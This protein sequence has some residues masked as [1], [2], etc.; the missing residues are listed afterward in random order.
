MPCMFPTPRCLA[1]TGCLLL[2]RPAT[3]VQAQSTLDSLV[4][5]LGAMTAVSGYEQAM[6]DTL[7]SLLPGAERDRAGNVVVTLGS[8][9]PKRLIA[10]PI[11]EPGY[12][13]GGVQPDG[14]LT[15]RRVGPNPGPLTDQQ[16]E[17]Q[18]VT[19]WGRRGGL[20]GVVGVRSIHLTRGRPALADPPFP[21]DDAFVDIG[22]ATA[23]EA[24][25][26]GVR[27]LA[28]VALEKQPHRYADTLVATPAAG[29]RGACAALLQA[30]KKAVPRQGTWLI[31]F[32]VEQGFTQRGLLSLAHNQ[33]PFAG[34][35][36]LDA[37]RGREVL[38]DRPSPA[39]ALLPS[40]EH[41]LL[42]ARYVGTP[43]ETVSLGDVAALL[44]GLTL[45]I[46]GGE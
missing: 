29:R 15:L 34:S 38:V 35:I 8:G 23:A 22:A 40:M 30:A 43:V 14:Y 20:P 3:P 24:R 1:L 19:V 45:R 28:P 33:G 4:L 26:L 32:V 16:L 21:L 41:W 10:C 11:D 9:Q 42:P 44:A 39:P 37:G 17:G 12:V 31:A 13:V 46:E 6:S 27:V 7:R 25:A 36:L 18:R 2:A 5:R